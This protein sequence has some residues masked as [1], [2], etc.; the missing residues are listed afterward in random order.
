MPSNHLILWGQEEKG[1]TIF[2]SIRVFSNESVLG[3][4]WPKYWS[5]SFNISPSSE[6][7]GLIS[8]QSRG[9][10]RDKDV[11][12]DVRMWT[13]RVKMHLNLS[14]YQLQ[15]DCCILCKSYGIHSSVLVWRIPGTGEPG[16]LL[17]MGS[18]RVGHDWSDLAAAAWYPQSKTYSRQKNLDIQLQKTVK[19]QKERKEQEQ[20]NNSQKTK[21]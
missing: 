2:P 21:R 19:S 20:R 13:K 16:G 11:N 12:C 17:S 15:I 14:C 9:L 1:T 10:S 7:P 6:H 18:H 4:R 8:L 5:F 3:I